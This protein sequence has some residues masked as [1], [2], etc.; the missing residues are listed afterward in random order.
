[1]RGVEFFAPQKIYTIRPG[2]AGDYISLLSLKPIVGAQY[3]YYSV[4][5]TN[6]TYA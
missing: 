5:N 1:M 6:A 2:V 3:L 4:C